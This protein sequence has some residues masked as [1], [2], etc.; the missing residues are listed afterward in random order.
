MNRGGGVHTVGR[1][2]RDGVGPVGT[3][4]SLETE[5]LR[6]ITEKVRDVIPEGHRVAVEHP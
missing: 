6:R 1:V 5:V 4:K 3:D 2:R